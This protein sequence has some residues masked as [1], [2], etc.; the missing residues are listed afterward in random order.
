MRKQLR[1]FWSDDELTQ[2]SARPYDHTRWE[3]HITR[4][5]HTIDIVTMFAEGKH[6]H[7]AADLS[8]GDGAIIKGLY[9]TGV[10]DFAVM[11][12]LV[13]AAHVH[14]RFIGKIEDTLP[15]LVDEYPPFDL[16]VL[17]ETIEHLMNP[18]EAL[19][20]IRDASK[21]LILSTPI[22]EGDG[23]GNEEHYWSWDVQDMSD[24]LLSAGWTSR[25]VNILS[26]PW[27][28][29]QIWTCTHD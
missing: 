21:N 29:Y 12:D 4:V 24:M 23:V 1:P 15:K 14:P 20:L 17:S 10:I 27:Y 19:R 25:D 8:C 11:G 16:F 13:S 26:L 5:R 28:S 22:A 3:D 9:A 2:V 6:W 18:D 7:S